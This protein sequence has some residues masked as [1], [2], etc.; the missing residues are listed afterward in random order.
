MTG[1]PEFNGAHDMNHNLWMN[2]H[3][4]GAVRHLDTTHRVSNNQVGRARTVKHGHTKIVSSQVEVVVFGRKT[5][6]LP[7]EVEE[8]HERIRHCLRKE[9]ASQYQVYMGS[10]KF[11]CKFSAG[12]GNAGCF[13]MLVQS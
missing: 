4:F 1:Y 8:V 12:L 13:A 9:V 7:M 3:P 5:R 6:M 10:W 11:H 2:Y